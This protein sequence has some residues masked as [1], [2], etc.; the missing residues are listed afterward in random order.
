MKVNTDK[1]PSVATEYGI[2]SI[3]TVMLFKAGK[4]VDAIIGAVKKPT[5]KSSIEKYIS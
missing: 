4:K 5:L 3:P 2:R 1:S